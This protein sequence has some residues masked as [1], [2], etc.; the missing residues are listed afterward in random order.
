MPMPLAARDW[1]LGDSGYFRRVC[2]LAGLDADTVRAS[3]AVA[4]T[5]A[6]RTLR[7]LESKQAPSRLQEVAGG[8]SVVMVVI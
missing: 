4:I 5:S 7:E 8:R 1:L 6:D 3:A 2:D